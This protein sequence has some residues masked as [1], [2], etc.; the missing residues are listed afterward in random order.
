MVKFLWKRYIINIVLFIKRTISEIEGI[1]DM[2]ASHLQ[3]KFSYKLDIDPIP[4]LPKEE[5]FEENV[6]NKESQE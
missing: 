1:S 4:P 6:E 3:K 5:K 2:N